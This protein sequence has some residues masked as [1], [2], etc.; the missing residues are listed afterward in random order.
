MPPVAIARLV[1]GPT[2]GKPGVPLQPLEPVLP[3]I[4]AQRGV[5]GARGIGQHGRGPAEI[6]AQKATAL[7]VD[8]VAKPVDRATQAEYRD[9]SVPQQPYVYQTKR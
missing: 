8:V 3:P 9:A 1:T 7:E 4:G 2:G 6:L 5:S